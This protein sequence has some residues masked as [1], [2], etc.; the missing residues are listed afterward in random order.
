MLLVVAQELLM[1]IFT[2][3][4]IGFIGLAVL[5]D[6]AYFFFSSRRRHTR[7]IG[8]WSS[9][10]CSSDLLTGPSM[11][12]SRIWEKPMIAERGVRSSCDTLARNSDFSLLARASSW[13]AAWSSE[14]RC[15]TF[16]SSVW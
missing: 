15:E 4:F 13:L 7:Y 14:V 10:V 12:S 16:S 1:R 9:D 5:F 3:Q 2:E 11:P 6:V 8:D